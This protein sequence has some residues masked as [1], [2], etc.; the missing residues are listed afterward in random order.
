LEKELK[1]TL[2]FLR[3]TTTFIAKLVPQIIVISN[4]KEEMEIK[5]QLVIEEQLQSICAL[6]CVEK[7]S[8]N[9][10]LLRNNHN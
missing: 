6:R 4:S 9:N 5:L 8:C 7:G 10:L 3:R 1:A 2:N